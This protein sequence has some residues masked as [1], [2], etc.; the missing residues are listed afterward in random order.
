MTV[1]FP[2]V[3]LVVF[4]E[5]GRNDHAWDKKGRASEDARQVLVRT[6]S[7]SVRFRATFASGNKRVPTVRTGTAGKLQR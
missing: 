3:G 7:G 2:K 5:Y 6:W 1:T 4:V